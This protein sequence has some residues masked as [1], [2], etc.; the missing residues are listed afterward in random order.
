MHVCF[1]IRK[2]DFQAFDM[3]VVT[4]GSF[5]GV[6]V[7][8]Q[9]II[10]RLVEK[11]KQKR[12]IGV[13]VTYEPHPQSVVSPDDAPLLLTTLDEKL[14][15][16]EGL[17]VEE[18]VVMSFDEQLKNQ[19]AEEF[20]EEI[21]V[22]KL[23]VGYLVVG[24]DHAFGKER[25][26]G[27]D[28]LKR[29][30]VEYGFDVEVVPHMYVDEKRVSSTRIRKELKT[31]DFAK[32]IKMLGHSYPLSG[33]VSSGKG[34]GKSLGYPTLNLD[35]PPRKLLPPDGV[36]SLKAQLQGENYPGM[37]HIGPKPTF[38]DDTRSVEV[39]L[40]GWQ[41]DLGGINVELLVER[42]I[43]ESKDFT[44]PEQLKGQL[45]SDEKRIKEM[46]GI[47]RSN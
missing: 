46:F 9:S 11:S 1:D 37:M 45:R 28:L 38:K 22:R 17:G 20:V 27:I 26:G 6:H 43:R 23:Q 34:R 14:K 29:T 7:G 36:Y 41:K 40:F 4:L 24:E 16:L 21:L 12:K 19:S 32:T 47:N 42:W 5:D 39:H 8:H 31:G 18:T 3:P 2:I 33:K 44:D 35:V 10:R 15:L 25:A 30:A 13:V